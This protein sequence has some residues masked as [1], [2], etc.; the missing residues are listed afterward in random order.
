MRGLGEDIESALKIVIEGLNFRFN[1]MKIESDKLKA[2][3]D[4]KLSSFNIAKKLLNKWL[5]SPNRPSQAKFDKYILEMIS[6]GENSLYILRRALRAEI[7]YDVLGE[8]K[9]KLA[10]ESKLFILNSINELE[11]SVKELHNQYESGKV[12][13]KEEEFVRGY[14]EKFSN[15]EFYPIKNYYKKWHNTE[16]DAIVL[17][18]KGSRGKI[19]KLEG[20]KIQLPIPP[21]DR[22][23]I[24]F[25]DLPKEEQCWKRSELP[26]GLTPDNSASFIDYILEEYRRRREGI[27]FMNNGTPVYL[28]GHNYY[29][30]QW[31]KLLDDGIYPDF[32]YAQLDMFYHMGACI[33]DGRSLGQIFLK[34]RRTGF[35][36]IAV[37]ISLNEITGT[38]NVKGGLTSKKDIDAKRC[39][40]KQ[41]YMFQELPFFFQPILKGRADSPNKLEFGKPSDSTKE[42]K[43]LRDTSTEGYV[44]STLDFES[45]ITTAYDGQKMKIYIGD[46]A[47]KHTR[48]DYI[49]HFNTLLPT[50]FQGGR[51]LGQCLLGSTMA[52]IEDGGRAFKVLYENSKVRDRLSSGYTSTKLYSFFLPAHK[53]YELCID[54]YG[55]CY[56]ETPPEGTVN[57]YGNIIEKGSIECIKELY[58]DAKKQGDSAL[59]AMHKAFPMTENHALRTDADDCVFNLTKLMDQMDSNDEQLDHQSYSRGTFEW[60]NGDRFTEVV[61]YPDDRGR[62]MVHWMPSDVDDTSSL[63]NNVKFERNVY[64]PMNDYGAIGVDCYGSYTIG[65]N[66]QSKGAA[67]AVSKNITLNGV[68]SNRVLYEYIDKPATQDVFNEDILKSAWFYGLPILAENNRRDFVR[69]LFL[70]SCRP[71]SMNRVDKKISVLKGD[72]LFLGGQNMTAKDILDSHE[73]AIRTYV[74]RYVGFSTDPQYRPE[75]EMGI[76][77][78]N[79]TLNDLMAFNPTS[80][81]AFDATI[82]IG[83]ALMGC[84]KEKYQPKPIIRNPKKMVSLLRKYS[85]SED[86]GTYINPVKNRR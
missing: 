40:A 61:W 65:S 7:D 46:E 21:R 5:N 42:A 48:M 23:K 28:T 69:Y 39:F 4:S 62:F 22:S 19:I 67:H 14:S 58:E 13:L 38:K 76:M 52:K 34:S 27:W 84:Q 66:K 72:D 11:A 85:I 29:Y 16:E 47:A 3:M 8:T 63:R 49:E 73:N 68:P 77:P 86:I 60:K 54:K 17:D 70:N 18:P 32:R 37:C 78:F 44:N 51:V 53:N 80:R 2:A 24:L 20:L 83:L 26:S 75:G 6:S 81:T 59:N 82:S 56:E 1:V 57:I 55:V 36:Y 10:I 41:S 64:Y 30:L 33:I 15:Q 31:C 43:K 12:V 79:K 45:S 71:F 25:S 74:Q 50:M 35:T 9:H